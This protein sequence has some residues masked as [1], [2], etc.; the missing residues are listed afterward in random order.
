[1]LEWLSAT[2]ETAA[3]G[4]RASSFPVTIR[5]SPLAIRCREGVI[6]MVTLQEL[7]E[8]VERLEREVAALKA[9]LR[10]RPPRRPLS[11]EEL[12]RRRQAVAALE[13]WRERLKDRLKGLTLTDILTEMRYGS[14]E[15][16][17]LS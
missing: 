10:R 4:E 7:A 3:N 9:Q 17:D 12:E 11:P 6:T 5:Y 1:M 14:E 15:G 8:R 13:A 16:C 2:T